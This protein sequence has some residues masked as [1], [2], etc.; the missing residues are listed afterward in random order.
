MWSRKRLD[1]GWRD[2]ACAGSGC[3]GPGNR[4]ELAAD[5]ERLWSPGE[6]I[7][8]LSVRSAF[9]LLLAALKLPP[10]SEVIVSAI[11]IE[12]MLRILEEHRLVAMPADLEIACMAPSLDAPAASGRCD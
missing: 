5:I 4:R 8:C 7:A 11:T 3:L 2:L 12:G 9:D 10:G 6:A 1:I